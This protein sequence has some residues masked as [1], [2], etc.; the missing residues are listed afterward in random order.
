MN[1]YER[2]QK[3]T[4]REREALYG[5][6]LIKDG[7][8]GN[9]SRETYIAYLGQAYHH[10]KH[11]LP[12]LMAAGSRIP[13]EKEWV[14]RAFAEYISEETGHEEW[15]LNDIRHAGGDAEAVRNAA[16]SLPV[17]LMTAYAWDLVMRRNPIGFF[18]MVFVLEGTSTALATHAAKAIGQSLN[19]KKDCFSY[20][21]SHG[22]L[23]VG[24]MR[25]FEQTVTRLTDPEDQ[26]DII[27]TA[28]V[29]F[30]LF[31]EMFRSIPHEQRKEAA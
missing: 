16:P 21:L 28:K 3:E 11:T 24:H 6:P 27:H 30:H 31:A 12:L 29:I 1:F 10:V 26:R 13:P 2:L 19:L 22:A 14:R 20:L 15:I 18:G 5:V 17:E 23:D 9:I 7:V 8:Q 4:E 25:F